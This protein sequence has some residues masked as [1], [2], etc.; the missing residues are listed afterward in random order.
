M[1]KD[2][3]VKQF[4][5]RPVS[6]DTVMTSRRISS[7]HSHLRIYLLLLLALATVAAICGPAYYSRRASAQNVRA[8]LQQ[9]L[10]QVFANHED[11]TL[12][13]TLAARV[14]E[15]GRMT[16]KTRSRDFELQL[17]P[18]DLRSPTTALKK[19]P[20]DSRRLGCRQ[21]HLQG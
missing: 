15:N 19:A 13:T 7:R 10:E 12:D 8:R 21:L 5:G 9:D 14:R 16:V 4:A 3:G 1:K 17:R 18:N 6:Y 20:T 11:V 2:K